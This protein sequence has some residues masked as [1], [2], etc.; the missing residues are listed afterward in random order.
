MITDL[1]FGLG[2]VA[3]IEGLVLALAPV[4]FDQLLAALREMTPENRRSVGLMVVTLGVIL[5]WAAKF[6]LG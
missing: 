1:L 2:F 6:V 4:R 3:I 5:V